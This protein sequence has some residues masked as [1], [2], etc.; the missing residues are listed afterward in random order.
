MDNFLENKLDQLEDLMAIRVYCAILELAHF[1][2]N[3]GELVTKEKPDGLI[4]DYVN[5]FLLDKTREEL[6][7]RIEERHRTLS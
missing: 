2:G 4:A 3:D 5:G 1:R 7:R 6:Y